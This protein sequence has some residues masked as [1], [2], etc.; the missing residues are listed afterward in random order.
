M[1][2]KFTTIC[3]CVLDM[4]DRDENLIAIQFKQNDHWQKL[5]WLEYSDRISTV[6]CALLAHQIQPG[7]RVAIMS[8]TRLEWSLV[9][10]A[11][12][13][14]HAVTVPIYQTATVDDLRHILNNA[15]VQIL[16]VENRGMYKN[17]LKVQDDC[18]TVKKVVCFE[19]V[20]ET[21]ERAIP[22]NDFFSLGRQEKSELK[23]KIYSLCK[24]VQISDLATIIYTSGTTGLPKGVALTHEQIISEISEA[25]EYCGVTSQ[26]VSLSF[27]PYAHVLGRIEHWGHAYF[28]FQMAYAEG[29]EKVKSNLSE[30]QPTILV[31]VPRIFEKIYATIFAQLSNNQLQKKI[32]DWALQVGLKAG[33]FKMEHQPLPLKQFAEL[34]LAQRLVLDKIKNAFGGRLRFAISGGAPI[35]KEI[36]LF[37]H[38]CGILV[39]EGYG[40]TETTAA[41]CVNTPFNYRFGSVGLPIGD[42]QIRLADDGEILV[43]SKKVMK[44]Y[45]NDPES[46]AQAFERGWFKTGDIG[47]FLPSGDL[48]ITDRKKDLIK[49]AGGKYV[50]PQKLE[51]L[52]KLNSSI[53]NVLIHGDN[54]KYIVA[55]ITLNIQ[56]VRDW[57]REKNISFQDEVSLSQHPAVLELIRKGVAEVNTKLSSHETIKRFSILTTDFTVESGELTPSL[58]VKRKFLDQK[59]KKQIEVLYN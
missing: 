34:Q 20:R 27:L 47:E 21:D 12:L 55:L 35:P 11:S 2:K 48:R 31:S 22:W 7:D 42:V 17:F 43:K 59:Y 6:A 44:E 28:G 18:P 30:I 10:L 56:A 37:F 53:S 24:S 40:L 16:F 13:S 25:F 57:A 58:K 38:A 51:S 26:D 45:Y 9:D 15:Q 32:F 8:N 1:K 4:P 19:T 49:T 3:E 29:L 33:H 50:A 23:S 5:S 36:A 41:I 52:L 54:K 14:I 39:L 46:T